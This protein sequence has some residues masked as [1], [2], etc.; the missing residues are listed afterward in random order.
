[1]TILSSLPESS[2]GVGRG[3]RSSQLDVKR[4]PLG[5]SKKV[6]LVL[7]RR[8]KEYALLFY[9]WALLC[10]DV[11]AGSAADVSRAQGD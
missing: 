6:V 5:V 2:L 9:L 1:M 3:P 7:K 10:L 4:S 11:L 8:H